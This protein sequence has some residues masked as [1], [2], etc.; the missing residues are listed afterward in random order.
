VVLTDSQGTNFVLSDN[1]IS[2]LEIGAD[3]DPVR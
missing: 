2:V 1:L 3:Q